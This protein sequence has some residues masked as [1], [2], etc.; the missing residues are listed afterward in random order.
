MDYSREEL[1]KLSQ[2]ELIDDV[3]LPLLAAFD[4]LKEQ[5]TELEAMV[6]KPKKDSN[7]SSKPPSTDFFKG[8]KPVKNRGGGKQGHEPHYRKLCEKPDKRV[9]IPLKTCPHCGLDHKFNS[10]SYLTHQVIELKSLDFEVIEYLRQKST[11]CLSG[12]SVLSANPPG[13]FDHDLFGPR[14]KSLILILYYENYLS[15][16]KIC[17]FL[18][19][20]SPIKV[21]KGAVLTVLRKSGKAFE[22]THAEIMS[23]IRNHDVVG[24]DE[25]GWRVS[26]KTEWLWAFQTKDQ[27]LYKIEKS[28]GSDVVKSVLG[29]EYN[30]TVI[31]DFYSAYSKVKSKGKQK[32]LAHLLRKLKYIFELTGWNPQGYASILRELFQEA[33][34]LKN[35]VPFNS[36]DFIWQR[37]L[38]ERRLDNYISEPVD[39]KEEKTI[40]KRLIKYRKELL[41]FLYDEQVDPTNNK[42][43]QAIR[44]RVIHRKICFGSRSDL[45]KETYATN[46]SIIETIKK[47]G[48]NLFEGLKEVLESKPGS[49]P[50]L[51]LGFTLHDTS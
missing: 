5:F 41:L 22:G 30:G 25:S 42:S 35:A 17:R 11:C 48:E 39:H 16:Q 33:I 44:P 28:R 2:E 24:I 50:L 31:S 38:L 27:V 34:H 14:L 3:I 40:Q 47:R 51:N 10:K 36:T 13:V 7:N 15:V 19:T 46:S 32:C 29:E 18:S 8:A 6:T 4:Q 49:K 20:F 12:K 23:Q 9:F 45:G 43:E 26:G 21:S 37:D 1:L